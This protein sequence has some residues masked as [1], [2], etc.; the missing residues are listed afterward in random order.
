MAEIC[1]FQTPPRDVTLDER[2]ICTCTRRLLSEMT[3][4]SMN[5]VNGNFSTH[6]PLPP[7]T[8]FNYN[9]A[10]D[11][12][13]M[14]DHFLSFPWT[15][16]LGICLIKNSTCPQF[17]DNEWHQDIQISTA[18]L[19]ICRGHLVPL[20]AVCEPLGGCLGCRRLCLA[21]WSDVATAM[22]AMV[23]PMR[24]NETDQ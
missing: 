10:S 9:S 11:L 18:M 13:E 17:C 20:L 22:L 15:Q 5:Y 6:P 16:H 12:Y 14:K 8:S 19:S 1:F 4:M 7:L 23:N 2:L 24:C 3:E 21:P